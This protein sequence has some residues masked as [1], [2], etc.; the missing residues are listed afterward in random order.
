MGETSFGEKSLDDRAAN[1]D[2]LSQDN[3]L[4]SDGTLSLNE[5]SQSDG[6]TSYKERSSF[7]KK[8]P[9]NRI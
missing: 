2:K 9:L 3:T 6:G 4:L 8:F 5:D 1:D 7:V